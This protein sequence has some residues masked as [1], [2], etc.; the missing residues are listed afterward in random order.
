MGGG[1]IRMLALCA[2]VAL[3]ARPAQAWTPGEQ[4]LLA[5]A[6]APILTFHPQEQLFPVSPLAP[7]FDAE[8]PTCG[9]DGRP[10]ERR[11]RVD[12]YEALLFGRRLGEA[13]VFFRVADTGSGLRAGQVRVEYWLYYAANHYRMRGALIPFRAAGD[14]VHDLEHLFLIL[15]ASDGG[16]RAPAAFLLREV[17]ASAHGGS[18]IAGNHYRWTDAAG[19]EGVQVLVEQGSHALAPDVNGDGRYTV[20]ADSSGDRTFVWGIRDRGNSWAH[21]RPA[22]TD[23]RSTP[24]AIR[25]VPAGA[26]PALSCAPAVR[27]APYRL[28]PVETLDV[29]VP[30]MARLIAAE[31]QAHARRHWAVRLF[32]DVDDRT[33][34][35]PALHPAG[36]NARLV[37]DRPVRAERGVAVGFTPVLSPATGFISGR[38]AANLGVGWAPKAMVNATTLLLPGRVIGEVDASVWYP[39][40]AITKVLAGGQARTDLFDWEPNRRSLHAGVEFRVGRWRWRV[41][42]RNGLGQSRVEFKLYYFLWQ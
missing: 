13:V 9:A 12:A 8:S 15:E 6:F 11:G 25:L 40:D 36:R 24:D 23:P 41:L 3:S 17:W 2:M 16:A 19:P 27:C 18:S 10:G 21:F 33:L 26:D 30:A 5:E 4:R 37:A 32:G 28:E 34:L 42:A 20:G 38:Y 7:L 1:V 22:Y 31:R 29:S 14:H 35:A 39:I